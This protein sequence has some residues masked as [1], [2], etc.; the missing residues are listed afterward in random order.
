LVPRTS[1]LIIKYG[2]SIIDEVGSLVVMKILCIN[3]S[4][5]LAITEMAAA[6]VC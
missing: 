4:G 6:L 3:C 2:V 1:Y 5:G